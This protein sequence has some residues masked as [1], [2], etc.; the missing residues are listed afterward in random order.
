MAAGLRLR[1]DNEEQER[2]LAIGITKVRDDG[3]WTRVAAV[4]MVR[5]G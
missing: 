2:K 1:T 5:S 3:A 4:G